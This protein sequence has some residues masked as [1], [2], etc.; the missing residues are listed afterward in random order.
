MKQNYHQN[1]ESNNEYH[2]FSRAIGDEKLFRTT[3]NYKYFLQK[4]K[5]HTDSVC[6]LYAYALL[7]NHF[8]LVVKIEDEKTLLHIL[9]K[10]KKRNLTIYNIH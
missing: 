3:E 8:H 10:R 5:H 6:K 9:K 4:L 7:P 1:L 2:L